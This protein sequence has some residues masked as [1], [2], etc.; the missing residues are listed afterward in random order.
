MDAT[1]VS[2]N[3]MSGASWKGT[4]VD[5]KEM[6]QRGRKGQQRR[7]ERQVEE[8]RGDSGKKKEGQGRAGSRDV[9][10]AQGARPIAQVHV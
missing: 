7:R 5:T 10:G 9:E 4:R 6:Q 3:H 8:K 1:G 2:L